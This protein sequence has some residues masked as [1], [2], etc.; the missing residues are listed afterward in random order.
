MANGIQPV[1]QQRSNPQSTTS[2][3]TSETPV[4]TVTTVEGLTYFSADV[5]SLGGVPLIVQAVDEDAVRKIYHRECAG[6]S[7]GAFIAVKPATDI[8][9]KRATE[10]NRVKA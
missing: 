1:N 5:P 3:T 10:E 7:P 2:T 9:I 4:T 8:E 6:L